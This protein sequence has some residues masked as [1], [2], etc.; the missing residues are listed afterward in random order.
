MTTDTAG[1]LHFLVFSFNRGEFLRNCIESIKHCAPDSRITIW[2][3]NSTDEL[4]CGIVAALA[5]SST[6]IDVRQ[7]A[8]DEHGNRSKHG[9]LY[10]NLQSACASVADGSLICCIQDDMQLVR[11]ISSD[12]INHWNLLLQTGVHKGFIQPAFL[13]AVSADIVFVAGKNAYHVNRQHRSAGAWY[14]DVFMTRIDLLRQVNWQF[15]ARESQNELQARDNFDQMVYLK[16]P[17]VAWLPGAPAWRGKRRTW[18]MRQA[19]RS[20]RCGFYPLQIM[21]AQARQDFCARPADVLPLAEEFLQLRDGNGALEKPWF[22]YPLQ[23]K[24]GLKL[25]NKIELL[26]K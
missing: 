19:E 10:N 17:F 26:F 4:T 14:S 20:R 25:L 5:G 3:D 6:L 16:N 24:R 21:S 23:G 13:K 22:Y 11:S 7:P 8:L 1:N 2:D 18:A 12:E 15:R 9:G